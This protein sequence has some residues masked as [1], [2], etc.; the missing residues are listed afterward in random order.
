MATSGDGGIKFS[1]NGGHSHA[2]SRGQLSIDSCF[3]ELTCGKDTISHLLKILRTN[4]HFQGLCLSLPSSSSPPP[5]P[6]LVPARTMSA[7]LKSVYAGNPATVRGQSTKISADPKGEKVVYCQNRT[8]FVRCITDP[9]KPALAYSQHT[10]PT[11]VA[12]ISPTGYYCASADQA[13]DRKSVV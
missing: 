10:Q 1:G 11:T 8:V 6:P 9:C 12:R 13:G 3:S 7:T 4:S 5:S 2:F